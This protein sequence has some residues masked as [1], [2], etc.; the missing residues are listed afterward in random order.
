MS[1]G[2]ALK[3]SLLFVYCSTCPYSNVLLDLMFSHNYITPKF[4]VIS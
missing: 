1:K 2:K 4:L 3:E